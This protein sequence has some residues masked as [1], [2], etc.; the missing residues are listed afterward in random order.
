MRPASPELALD[1]IVS[2]FFVAQ[3][4]ADCGRVIRV[5]RIDARPLSVTCT[6][7]GGE[8]MQ[9]TLE[10]VRNMRARNR[11]MF[12]LL[13]GSFEAHEV[14]VKVLM[15]NSPLGARLA[16][17]PRL[18]CAPPLLLL[19]GSLPRA[20]R[21][22]V[23]QLVFLPVLRT[24]AAPLV[25]AR[26]LTRSSAACST[27]ARASTGGTRCARSMTCSS[28]PRRCSRSTSCTVT[29]NPRYAL[30]GMIVSAWSTYTA[31]AAVPA[32]ALQLA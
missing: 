32:H 25:Q 12:E 21:R 15:Q 29:S 17:P 2:E 24:A 20:V 16:R 11:D 13:K 27:S 26:W 5:F 1:A 23:L 8:F 31:L 19:E 7:P 10:E 28:L 14:E 3:A 6:S 22:A 30:L 4:L 9:K 18:L